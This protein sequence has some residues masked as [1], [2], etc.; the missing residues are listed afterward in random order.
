MAD[1]VTSQTIIDGART[2]VI[3][4]VSISDGTGEADAVAVDVSALAANGSG[5]PCTGVSVQKLWFWTAGMSVNMEW[6][7]TTDALIASLPADRE[8][9]YDFSC[10]GGVPNNAGAGKTGDILFT[11]VGHSA[12][13][14]Y[15][16]ILEMTKN[17]G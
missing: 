5:D 7:A 14:T 13:D 2:C 10:F 3:K 6:D 1:A 11:T 17:Y 12:G 9:Y 16:V 15:T 8:G 4:R